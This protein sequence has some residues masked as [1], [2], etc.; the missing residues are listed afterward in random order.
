MGLKAWFLYNSSLVKNDDFCRK[1]LEESTPNE[2]KC[3]TKVC[4]KVPN[5]SALQTSTKFVS[6]II[7]N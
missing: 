7:I 2:D 3:G 1:I 6:F 4:M 5:L